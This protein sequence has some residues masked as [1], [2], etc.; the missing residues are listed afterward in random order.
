VKDFLASARIFVLS[1]LA[2]F[3]YKSLW[4]T[5]KIRVVE[6]PDLLNDLS[7]QKSVI[8]AHWHGHELVLMP[9]IQ[10]YKLATMISTSKDGQIMNYAVSKMSGVYSS[11]SSTRQGAQAL[12]GLVRLMKSGKSACVAVDG[13]K[14]PLHEVKPGVFELSKL[15]GA[16][17]FASGVHVDRFFVSR[18]SW[19]KAVLPKPFA[20]VTIYF[21]PSGV[22]VSRVATPKDNHLRDKLASAINDAIQYTESQIAGSH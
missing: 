17:I 18:K 13:P 2:W 12:L 5:W 1:R 9:M 11:G 4:L 21:A 7:K 14:G 15:T 6:H 3:F 22:D 8:F 16:K 19:N 20:N 10:R